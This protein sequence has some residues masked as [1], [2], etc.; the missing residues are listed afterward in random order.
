VRI[1]TNTAT[2]IDI[3]AFVTA[4]PT[5]ADER[6]AFIYPHRVFVFGNSEEPGICDFSWQPR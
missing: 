3:A 4:S 6:V 1:G 2:G 5:G